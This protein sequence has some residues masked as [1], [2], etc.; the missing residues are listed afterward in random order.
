MPIKLFVVV[1]EYTVDVKFVTLSFSGLQV[2]H[3]PLQNLANNCS[4]I[5][6]AGGEHVYNFFMCDFPMHHLHICIK[7]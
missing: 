2:T 3:A 7:T 6:P 4:W 1:N 5:G